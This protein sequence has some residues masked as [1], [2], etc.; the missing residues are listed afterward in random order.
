LGQLDA[1]ALA[2]AREGAAVAVVPSRWHEPHP[3]AVSESMAAGLPVLAS[4][5]GGLPE[6]AGDD[7][8]VPPGDAEAWENA[9]RDLWSD[10]KLRRQR[11]EAALNRARERF[12]A[13][14][15]YERLMACYR[16]AL[17]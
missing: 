12:A 8:T 1:A 10:P 6:M 16:T 17:A 5:M 3:Y 9:L 14:G 7:S 13:D 15:Y 11:G 4:D 2:A